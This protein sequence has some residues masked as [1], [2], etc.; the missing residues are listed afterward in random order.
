[1]VSAIKIAQSMVAAAR[2]TKDIK[3]NHRAN[4]VMNV[5]DSSEKCG[6]VTEIYLGAQNIGSSCK[7][8]GVD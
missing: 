7:V 4:P 2:K 5:A 6:E 1:M 3:G 8:G